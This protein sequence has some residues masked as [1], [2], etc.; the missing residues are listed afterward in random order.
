MQ[1]SKRLNSNYKGIVMS[2]QANQEIPV[3]TDNVHPKLREAVKKFLLK[4]NYPFTMKLTGPLDYVNENAPRAEEFHHTAYFTVVEFYDPEYPLSRA[5]GVRLVI[6]RKSPSVRVITR[7]VINSRFR[8]HERRM[9]VQTTNEKKVVGLLVAHI[10]PYLLP[11]I[12]QK[13]WG[14]ANQLEHAW[15]NEYEI[16]EFDPFS[17]PR[18]TV[19]RELQNLLAQGAKF[20][21]SQFLAAVTT[22]MSKFETWLKRRDAKVGKWYVNFRSNGEVMLLDPDKTVKKYSSLELLPQFVQE[23]IAMLKILHR[24]GAI[25]GVGVQISS[26]EFWVLNI[27]YTS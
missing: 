5:G 20:V 1:S 27:E 7:N 15:R 9:S 25:P 18:S 8:D 21:S 2:D 24:P 11:E 22:G 26:N 10:K 13:S 19:H 14:K 23:A 3:T 4:C 6:G 16:S 12:A 17:M